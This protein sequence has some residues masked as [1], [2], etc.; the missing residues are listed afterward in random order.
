M[1]EFSVSEEIQDIKENSCESLR[2]FINS[3][4]ST[5]FGDVHFNGEIFEK[6]KL[7]G[8]IKTKNIFLKSIFHT[9]NI[10]NINFEGINDSKKIVITNE[11]KFINKKRKF[12]I[13]FP[14]Q[15]FIFEKGENRELRSLIDL[16]KEKKMSK[17]I[18]NHIKKRKEN[19][20]NIRKKIKCRFLKSLRN[21]LNRKLTIVGS[22]EKF[23]FL[24]Q[25]FVCNVS[26]NLNKYILD[27][28][29]E[30]VFSI[31]FIKKEKKENKDNEKQNKVNLDKYLKN[32]KVLEY[33]KE[34]VEINEQLNFN[35]IK[36][37][38]LYQIFDEYLISK[39]FEKDIEIM[40]KKEEKEKNNYNYIY[41]YINLACNFINF[42][43]Q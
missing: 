41:D 34:N 31:N 11:Q 42:F 12:K 39:E 29:I 2:S 23:D 25:S 40:K 4:D 43:F 37:M 9:S 10:P 30:E 1:T 6:C 7:D 8:E 18:R 20:D 28:T 27:K 3:E 16:F 33:I 24:P 35:E 15:F 13:S 21:S 14:N 22:K 38:K 32:K 17:K 19:S 26:K 5:L 36:K